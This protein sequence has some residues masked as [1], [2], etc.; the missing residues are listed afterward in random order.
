MRTRKL[1]AQLLALALCLTLL[2]PLT[3]YA[4]ESN[5]A[6]PADPESYAV[7]D[8]DAMKELVEN[9]VKALGLNKEKISV[10][11]CYLDTG[12]TWYYNGDR[13]YY[14]ASVYKVPLMMILAEKEYNGE[15]DRDTLIGGIPLGEAESS[16]I[17]WSNNPDAHAVMDALG[18][19]K[20]VRAMYRAYSPLPE[21]Y[22]DPDFLDYSYFT[23]R[24][25][26]DVIKTL[27]YE[28]ERFP[29]IIECMCHSDYGMYFGS[30]L[31]DEYVIAQKY[32]CFI[33]RRGVEYNNDTGIIYTEHP[34]VLTVM[35]ENM[36]VTERVLRDMAVIFK[37]Y[38]LSLDDA[39]EAW[40]AAQESAA[41]ATP[42]PEETTETPSGFGGIQLPVG[43]GEQQ[44]EPGQE[45]EQPRNTLPPMEL[46]NNPT[47]NRRMI[48]LILGAAI[49]VVMILALVLKPSLRKKGRHDG[50]KKKGKRKDTAA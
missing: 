8:P 49:V 10:G 40:K 50:G 30:Y 17:T 28:N 7:I 47:N 48:L 4:E 38:T 21:E 34:F 44:T 26:T 12:D 45:T 36:G 9:Y 42:A 46:E 13:W 16:I 35:T 39:Y 37:D 18:T 23:A 1:F 3:A 20:E 15:I 43:Q 2:G 14:S 11:Y 29:N 32:G 5:S 25:T 31:S 27:Y 33:D 22:Y 41:Q 19:A 6:I 24:F